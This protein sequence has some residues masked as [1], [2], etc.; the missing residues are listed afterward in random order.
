[1]VSRMENV[2][3]AK[4]TTVWRAWEICKTAVAPKHLVGQPKQQQD[5]DPNLGRAKGLKGRGRPE[6]EGQ[7]PQ[8]VAKGAQEASAVANHLSEY[9]GVMVRPQR[10]T[11]SDTPPARSSE[12]SAVLVFLHV[13][14][15][16]GQIASASQA[17]LSK[18]GAALSL[19]SFHEKYLLGEEAVDVLAA[20]DKALLAC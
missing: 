3:V 11:G 7:G 1:M 4:L 16:A 13:M 8:R 6:Y 10:S 20:P 12:W 19:Q 18:R 2:W 17:D 14:V 5:A 15:C 9:R